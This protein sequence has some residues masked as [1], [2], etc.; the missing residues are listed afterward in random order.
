MRADALSG[1]FGREDAK[2]LWADIRFLIT[3]CRGHPCRGS[4]ARSPVPNFLRTAGWRMA[5]QPYI[6]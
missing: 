3:G 6:L 2:R 5:V 4:R 1:D